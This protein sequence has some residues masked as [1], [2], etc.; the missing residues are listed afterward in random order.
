[1]DK[2]QALYSFWSS[3]G[4]TAYDVNTVPDDATLPYITYETATDSLD[5]V[6]SLTA[7]VWYRSK[8]WELIERKTAEIARAIYAMSPIQLDDG[9]L[10]LNKGT[11]FAQRMTDPDDTI[12]RMIINVQAEFLTAY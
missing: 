6:L 5:N 3:F 2:A 8:S 12:R 11:P 7:S 9:Y 1:M 10:W 4:I